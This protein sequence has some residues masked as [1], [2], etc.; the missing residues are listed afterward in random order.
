[1]KKGKTNIIVLGLSSLML[2]AACGGS[3]GGKKA[4]K[5][6]YNTYLST[7]PKTWNVHNWETSDESYVTAFTEMGLYDLAFN[8]NRDGYVVIHEMAEDFPVDVSEEVTDDEMDR[9]GYPGNIDE[10]F[11][12]DIKLNKNAKFA[13]GKDINATT[14]V[15][16]MR[17]QLDPLMVNYRADS[18]YASS[19]VVANAERYFKQGRE[20]IEALFNYVDMDNTGSNPKFKD[21]NVA[22]DGKFFLNIHA[23]S[24]F[25]GKIFA[26][27]DGSEGLYVVLNNRGGSSTDA[28]ELAAQRIT[29]ACQ[30]YC[31]KYTSHEGEFHEK[32][33]EIVGYSK[34]SSITSEMMNVNIDLDDFDEKDVLVRTTKDDSSEEH[35]QHYSQALLKKDLSTVVTGLARVNKPWNWVLPLFGNVYND[36]EESFENVGIRALDDYT[37]RIYLAKKISLLDLEFAL[38][39]NWIVDVELYDSQIQVTKTGY[40]TTKYATPGGG[41]SGYNSYG[42]YKLTVFES[43]KEIR[44]TRN[45]NWYGW[46]DGEHEGQYNITDVYT[47]IITDHNVA[48]QEFEAG[49]LDDI[50]LNRSDMKIYGNSSRKTSS[51]E[52]YTQKISFNSSRAKLLSRQKSGASTGNKTILANMNFRKGLSLAMDRNNFASQATAGSKAFTGLLNDLY[53]TDVAHGEMYRNTEQGKSVY[54]QVYGKLGGDPYAADYQEQPLAEKENGYNLAMATKYVV[55]ALE[56]EAASELEG[57]LAVNGAISLEFRVYDTESEATKEMLDFI[58]KAF[59]AVIDAANKKLGTTYSISINAQKDED[60]YNSAKSGNYDLIFSTWGGAAINPIGLMEVYCKNDFE[61][62]CEYGF[63]GKQNSTY[64][65]IDTNGDGIIGDSERKTFNNWWSEINNMTED[66][67][68]YGSPEYIKKHNYILTVLAGLEAGILNRFEAVPLVARATTSLNSFKIENGSKVYINLMGY[69][70]IRYLTFNMNDAE[71]SKFINSKDYSADLY[72]N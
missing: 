57:H 64:L 5:Y 47:R 20:T 26:G 61:S 69:G 70:G 18:Y 33:E 41:V 71:W 31:W 3:S 59:N 53:L 44:M 62:C 6:T 49:R 35:T 16:S 40:K 67:K 66:E 4:N 9:Y 23:G 28:V 8:E 2:L 39:G 45:E 68:D 7:K 25:A 54:Q 52:S 13:S 1:M 36:Y 21:D 46:T 50:D 10:G 72:K 37:I 55:Q 19:L 22:G 17:R 15:E 48:L 12:W 42:P 29:D 58:R 11:V 32:W 63:K 14:Y 38:S 24:P 65:E 43:G 27:T 56:E 51:Y 30:Y 60:Y 34:L